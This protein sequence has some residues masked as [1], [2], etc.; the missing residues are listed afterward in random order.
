MHCMPDG[1]HTLGQAPTWFWS[2]TLAMPGSFGGGP[3]NRK[4][5][6]IHPVTW[7]TLRESERERFNRPETG[8]KEILA[9][10]PL[11]GIIYWPSILICY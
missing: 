11:P 9:E 2:I 1:C 3:A 5:R 10:R 7:P 8:P 6:F 4:K